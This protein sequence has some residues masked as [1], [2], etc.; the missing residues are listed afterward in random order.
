MVLG[1]HFPLAHVKAELICS[2][3]KS[4]NSTRQQLASDF[5]ID[6]HTLRPPATVGSIEK[7]VGKR[8]NRDKIASTQRGQALFWARSWSERGRLSPFFH[9]LLA[10]DVLKTIFCVVIMAVVLGSV[11]QWANAY[12]ERLLPQT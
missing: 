11:R 6:F 1:G 12:Q 4:S 10:A 5:S 8:L 3:T 2:S 9:R 7:T